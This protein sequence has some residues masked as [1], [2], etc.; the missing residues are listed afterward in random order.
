MEQSPPS[1]LPPPASGTPVARWRWWIHLFLIG[2]Y[3]L[4]RIAIGIQ[5]PRE[6]PA[7]S[8][9][10]RGLL[11]VCTIELA[12][13]A[14]AFALGWLASRA[15][16]EDLFLRWR[17]GWWVIP[18][19]IGY[20]IVIRLAAGIVIFAVVVALIGT[21]AV[22]PARA[23]N[24]IQTSQ[25]DVAKLVDVPALRHDPAYF[26]LTI[27]L[28]SF[29][30][31][32]LREEMWRGGTLAAMRALWPRAFHSFRGQIVA[33]ALIAVLF[34]AG[35]LQLGVLGAVVAGL[36]GLFLGVV[37]VV[38]RSIWPAVIAH[39]FL[40]ATTFALIPLALEKL[41]EFH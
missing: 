30:V 24:F 19:G 29:V 4:P 10:W 22:A 8:S 14:L 28:V 9:N 15:S 38:H 17:P 37:I 36:L 39:G 31:A 35:H 5:F 33:I 13:F 2:G 34:G 7:L 26:W 25:P 6:H 20:S 12:V 27:T 41:K 3:V 1:A 40:D 21:H 18:L 32:G 23:Q 11:I 16:S